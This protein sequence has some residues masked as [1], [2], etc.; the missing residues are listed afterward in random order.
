MIFMV[1]ITYLQVLLAVVGHLEG[2]MESFAG[3]ANLAPETRVT[4]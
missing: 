2:V 4:N 1:H 3:A